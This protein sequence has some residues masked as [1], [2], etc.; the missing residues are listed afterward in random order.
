MIRLI[1][2]AVARRNQVLDFLRQSAKSQIDIDASIAAL[3]A[4]FGA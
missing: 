2:E 4:E 1:D 3:Q